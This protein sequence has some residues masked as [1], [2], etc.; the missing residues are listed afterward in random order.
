MNMEVKHMGDHLS[1]MLLVL[2]VPDHKNTIEPGKNGGHKVDLLR[3]LLDAVVSAQ[4]G[5]GGR[6]DRAPR[7][8]PGSDPSLCHTDGLLLHGLMDGHPILRPHLIKL[9]DTNQS[10]VRPHQCS[11]LDLELPG[12]RVLVDGSGQTGCG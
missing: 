5:V 11:S 10:T 9:V 8:Q 12:Y 6:Q 7:V 2:C 4:H 3:D 1:I